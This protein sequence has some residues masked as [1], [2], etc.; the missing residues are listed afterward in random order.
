MDLHPLPPATD[1]TVKQRLGWFRV[2]T[3]APAEQGERLHARQKELGLYTPEMARKIGLT[4]LE[5]LSILQGR[6]SVS[7]EDFQR[8]LAALEEL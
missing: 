1:E 6:A 5:L 3:W 7:D 2:K 8:L 4:P